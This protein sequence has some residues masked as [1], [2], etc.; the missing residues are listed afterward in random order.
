MVEF[1][2][3][4]WRA[5]RRRQMRWHSSCWHRW[6]PCVG[7]FLTGLANLLLNSSLAR[8]STASDCHRDRLKTG[9][10][11]SLR[12][13]V[14]ES[15]SLNGSTCEDKKAGPAVEL[16]STRTNTRYSSNTSNTDHMDL[17]APKHLRPVGEATESSRPSGN[18][19]VGSDRTEADASIQ[20]VPGSDDS[21]V[22]N[23]EAM[24]VITP[25]DYQAATGEALQQTL[26]LATWGDAGRLM[27]AF[28]RLEAEIGQATADERVL[29]GQIRDVVLPR[30][31]TRPGAPPQAGVFRVDLGDIRRV[32]RAALFN[33]Q[34]EACDGVSV[35]YDTLPL[36]IIQL[37]V[38]M[39]A[40]HGDQS[41]W[42]HRIFRRDMRVRGPG[43]VEDQVM[44]FL[45]RRHRRGGIGQPSQRDQMSDM[46]RRAIMTFAERAVL[47]DHSQAPWR[48]GHGSPLAHELL[49]GSGSAELIVRSLDVLRRLVLD[50]KR[51]VFVPSAPAE[52]A[53]LT[54][55]NALRPLEYAVIDTV[56]DRLQRT[57][58]QGGYR[59][60]EFRKAK[61]RL[62]EFAAD[63]GENVLIGVYRVSRHSPA[64]AFYAH[65]D[66]VSEAALIAMA[67]SVLLD[68]RGFPM[69]LD[70]ADRLCSNLMGSETLLRP[71][72]TAYAAAGEPLRYQPE[73]STRT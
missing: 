6:N 67:D 35:I 26:D 2:L 46:F 8:S 20:P 58:E 72:L 19:P 59:G 48:M 64:Q 14:L 60:Q 28:A 42:S 7:I 18:G 16:A 22:L 40:Y 34:V 5:W 45:D 37:G 17:G 30:L 70:L 43:S 44:E 10:L 33:G 65:V 23:A 41:T 52:R 36:T 61:R 25:N 15:A 4:K 32:Q 1:L 38:G 13:Y 71:A 24:P 55:G 9:P 56:A 47:A 21:F 12:A 62:Q 73:R 49:T 51:F 68:H 57:I 11:S 69:L 63:A 54:I 27:E 39:V 31:K 3:A 53:L 29:T 66:H 50:H